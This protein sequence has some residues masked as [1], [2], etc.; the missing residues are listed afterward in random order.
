M[1]VAELV[2]Q[3]EEDR[4]WPITVRLRHP[5]DFGSQHIAMLE[6][7]RG[8]LADIKGLKIAAEMPSEHLILIAARLSGQTTNVIERLDYEDAGEVLAIAMDFYGQ[9]LGGGR[10]R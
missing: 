3:P 9:C 8:K 5:L 4:A 7:R 10:K 1:A 6:F 2:E